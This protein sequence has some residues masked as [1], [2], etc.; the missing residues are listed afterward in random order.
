LGDFFEGLFGNSSVNS[1]TFS[2]FENCFV[3][4][5]LIRF[6]GLLDN[7]RPR[8]SKRRVRRTKAKY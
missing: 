4:I 6:N 1:T 5:T 2:F 3:C 8:N 7:K